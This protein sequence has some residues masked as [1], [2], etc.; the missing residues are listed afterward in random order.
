L[1]DSDPANWPEG[2]GKS[3]PERQSGQLEPMLTSAQC[4]HASQADSNLELYA[5]PEAI[6]RLFIHRS[7]YSF[8]TIQYL[9]IEGGFDKVQSLNNKKGWTADSQ[10]DKIVM[11]PV[12]PPHSTKR[13]LSGTYFFKAN[14]ANR[15]LPLSQNLAQSLHNPQ[16]MTS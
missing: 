5:I 16:H 7:L 3:R 12:L 11:P 4:R 6:L 8:N 9:Q 10:K 15:S 2:D 1:D 14:K 13:I